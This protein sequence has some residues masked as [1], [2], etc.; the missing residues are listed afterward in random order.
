MIISDDQGSVDAGCYGAKDVLTP[1]LD[2]LAARGVRFTQF[3]SGAPVCSPS[4][5]ALL[6]GRYPLR[7]GVPS[8]AA[9]QAGGKEGLPAD[10]VTM[11]DMFKAAGYATGLVGKWH[12]GYTPQ[13]IPTSHGFDF[14]YGHMGGCIDNYSHYF[15]W[16]GPNVHD[17][18]R[19]GKE[20][21]E[22]GKYFPDLM[23]DQAGAF[24]EQNK[25]RPFFLYFAPNFPHYPYQPD[26]KWLEHYKDLPMPRRLYAAQLSTMDQRIGQ[27]LKKVDE[28]G[29]RQRT[30]VVYQTDHGHSTEERAFFGGGSAG[31]YR[32]AKFSLFEGGIRLPAIISWPGRIPEGQVRGQ[33]SHS[34]DW[35]PTVAELCGVK[36]V[37]PD[38][39]G[40]SI[41]NVIKS[42]DAPTPHDVVHWQM[43]TGPTAQWA[44]RQGP[45][46]LIGNAWDTSVNDRARERIDL[47]LANLDDDIGEK[48]NLVSDRPETTLRLRKLHD[49]WVRSVSVRP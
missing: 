25:D 26:L 8:N 42:A 27:L 44:I 36:I 17:L 34:C 14:A 7:C 19:N 47:F 22:E 1:T 28:L 43:G 18:Y 49:D 10:E 40:T 31:S 48:K 39:D 46:K 16:Q 5:A 11:A 13:T 21:H 45:W 2:A 23:V 35:L 20:I 30:I 33:L 32:G 38:I 37:N 6:T 4:R 24:L 29:L 15:Y 3:Y 12:L 9:S 41:L